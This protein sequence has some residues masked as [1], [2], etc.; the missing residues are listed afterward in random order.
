MYKGSG[1][2][3]LFFDNRHPNRWE[4]YL[5]MVLMSCW[6]FLPQTYI[7]KPEKTNRQQQQQR[8]AKKHLE[9]V[10]ESVILIVSW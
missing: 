7:H 6:E 3:C 8:D 5:L 9:V 10:V 2:F 4:G 1:F